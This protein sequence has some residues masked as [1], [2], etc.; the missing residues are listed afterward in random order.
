LKNSEIESQHAETTIKTLKSK[1]EE[2][3][4]RLFAFQAVRSERI[5]NNAKNLRIG[6]PRRIGVTMISDQPLEEDDQKKKESSKKLAERDEYIRRRLMIK[7]GRALNSK[8]QD[9]TYCGTKM[10]LTFAVVLESNKEIFNR[11]RKNQQDLTENGIRERLNTVI[12]TL[13]SKIKCGNYK[14]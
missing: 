1:T 12:D 3:T 13:A 11:W 6:R 10:P 5:S 14:L 8:E 7:L 4:E 2:C 9:I